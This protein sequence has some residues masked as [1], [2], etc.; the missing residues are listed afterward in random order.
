MKFWSGQ[1]ARMYIFVMI[2]SVKEDHNSSIE[3]QNLIVEKFV[4]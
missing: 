2:L 1:N 3:H 4:W